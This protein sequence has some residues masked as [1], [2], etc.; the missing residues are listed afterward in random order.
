MKSLTDRF[1]LL[2]CSRIGNAT[3][4]SYFCIGNTFG[5][6]SDNLLVATYV[7]SCFCIPVSN[8]VVEWVFNHDTS[9]FK[10][11]K[12]CDFECAWDRY[13]CCV[14]F[15]CFQAVFVL[16]LTVATPTFGLLGLRPSL[17]LQFLSENASLFPF[18][19]CATTHNPT[20]LNW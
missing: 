3:A 19:V 11:R 14:N 13:Q 10:I 20:S 15:A 7:L 17:R 12:S 9:V 18:C 16:F 5:I 8:T 4:I 2:F 6:L 1:Q